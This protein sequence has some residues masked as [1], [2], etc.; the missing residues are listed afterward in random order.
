MVCEANSTQGYIYTSFSI[1]WSVFTFWWGVNTWVF[2]TESTKTLHKM[3]FFVLLFQTLHTIFYGLSLLYCKTKEDAAYWGIATTSTF[4]L[5]YTFMYTTLSLI[6]RG[7]CILR[8]TL[9]RIEIISIGIIMGLVYLSFSAYLIAEENLAP[10]ILIVVGLLFYYCSSSCIK[11]IKYMQIRF[12]NLQRANIQLILPE[13]SNKI[14]QLKNFLYFSYFFYVNE[15]V[16]ITLYCIRKT[17][18]TNSLAYIYTETSV[19]LAIT[20][21]SSFKMFFALRQKNSQQIFDNSLYI[22]NEQYNIPPILFARIPYND[23]VVSDNTALVLTP[24]DLNNC[25][26]YSARYLILLVAT[27]LK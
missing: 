6:S 1:V 26:F 5:Y 7:F 22:H 18:K 25:K 4:I 21:I 2:S 17:E 8:E 19:Y 16:K 9:T 23:I 24:Q 27:P 3:I 15:L 11:I 10:L 12:F 13:V 14:F 20:T